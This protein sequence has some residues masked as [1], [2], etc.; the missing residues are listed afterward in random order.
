MGYNWKETNSF[1]LQFEKLTISE[2]HTSF[3]TGGGEWS[4]KR[5]AE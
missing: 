4:E 2:N 5:G 3:V 1:R